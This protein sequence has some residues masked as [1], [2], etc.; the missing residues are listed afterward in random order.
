MNS[1][2]ICSPWKAV[3]QLVNKG[4]SFRDAFARSGNDVESGNFKHDPSEMKHSHEGKFW[5]LR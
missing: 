4:V 5:Q 2:N 3:N 1:T